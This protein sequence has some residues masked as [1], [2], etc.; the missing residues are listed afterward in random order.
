MHEFKFDEMIISVDQIQEFDIST[1]TVGIKK[2]QHASQAK[3]T[4]VDSP[5]L[6]ES[7]STASWPKE[8]QDAGFTEMT[9]AIDVDLE[10][11]MSRTIELDC[12][13]SICLS[14]GLVK[15]EEEVYWKIVEDRKS[16]KIKSIHP[17]SARVKIN[18]TSE[19]N[20]GLLIR[21]FKSVVRKIKGTWEEM[22][23]ELY[24]ITDHALFEP[25]NGFG[26]KYLDT[27]CV[28]WRPVFKEVES[29]KVGSVV[30]YSFTGFLVM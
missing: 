27:D 22:V 28:T 13:Y 26:L 6:D 10:G 3:L 21:F 1:M 12:S 18:I 23:E 14:T 20:D 9:K 30:Y 29:K 15:D 2:S 17:I 16:G 5:V 8:F 11:V 24:K 25:D 19:E 7:K 4:L